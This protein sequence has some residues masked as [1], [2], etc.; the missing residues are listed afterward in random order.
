MVGWHH[1]LDGREFEQALGVGDGQE[2]LACCSSWGCKQSETTERL[3]WTEGRRKYLICTGLEY[4]VPG[5]SGMLCILHILSHLTWQPQRS[6]TIIMSILQV[7]KQTPRKW[8]MEQR[9]ESRYSKI[10]S[11]CSRVGG[12]GRGGGS[13]DL[14]WIPFGLFMGYSANGEMK[15]LNRK[16]PH[17]KVPHPP[18]H[19]CWW[20]I[21]VQH[22]GKNLQHNK[23]PR[24][25]TWPHD[26]LLQHDEYTPKCLQW[27]SLDAGN[28]DVSFCAFLGF[29]DFLH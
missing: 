7:R 20:D 16:L 22:A 27:L 24:G 25:K 18:E 4:Q 8:A 23:L 29:S 5:T 3:N 21:L 12:W 26:Y 11:P 14:S 17:G 19:L 2:S 28:M 6:P 13:L 10:K 15:T 9:F 1:Q